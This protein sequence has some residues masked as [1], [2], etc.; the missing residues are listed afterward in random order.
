MP[1]MNTNAGETVVSYLPYTHSFEQILFAF[2]L[3][4]KY[5]I[6]FYSGDPTRLVEDCGKLKPHV[7][8]SVPRLYN[9]I[10]AKLQGK[11]G[12]AS[13]VK[14]WLVNNA[15]AK[16][17][18]NLA[19]DGTLTACC[20]DKIV[21][22]KVRALLGGNVRYMLT[23]SAP[24]TKDVLEFLKISFSCPIL[25]GYGLT[26][27]AA[28]SCITEATDPVS[29]H[30]GGP[31]ESIKIRLK[32]LPD[33]NYLST[34][35]PYPRGEVC[36]KGP[37]IFSGY[38]KRPD[39]TQEAFDS[40]GWFL[41]GDVGLV[42]PNGSIRIIDRS[43]NIFKLS[44]GE[45]I[46]PEKIEQ[47]LTLSPMIAQC[48]VYGN[49]LKNNVVAVV[50]PEEVWAEQ[51]AKDNNLKASDF[52]TL[53]QNEDLKAEIGRDMVRL[54]TENKL[55]SL[56]KP[57]LFCLHHEL[58]SLENN[59]ITATFKLKRNVAFELRKDLIDEMYARILAAE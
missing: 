43:K 16:K 19:R 30:V 31:V 59:C 14:K 11:F 1:R 10:Y 37:A 23:G 26:E 24:I 12:E 58:F 55:S 57:K 47:I 56:E 17:E 45:Y 32:D 20:Y 7:F 3:V 52:E 34:D 9:K 2:A 54:A 36:L 18:A 46:A 41:T 13:G 42:Y 29:G 50:S 27:S 38:Y 40:E 28:G 6:G 22:K 48:F 8:P 44:Q 51:W 53:C 35:L 4:V 39:K 49:S 5:R 21:F 25:E 33:M 15:L